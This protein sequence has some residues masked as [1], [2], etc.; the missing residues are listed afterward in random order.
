MSYTWKAEIPNAVF[1]IGGIAIHATGKSQYQALGT[2]ASGGCTTTTLAASKLIRSKMMDTGRGSQPGQYELLKESAG[3]NRITKNTVSV[4]KIDR[5]NGSMLNGKVKLW[6][7]VII[8]Y[9]E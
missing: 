5:Y 6:D 2:R 1:F 4:Y 3:R 9:E 8:V 7:T